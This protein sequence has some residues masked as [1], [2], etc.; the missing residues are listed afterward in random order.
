[1]TYHININKTNTKEFLQIADSLKKLG[2]IK[3]I[4][5]NK[6]LVKEGISLNEDILS[7]ILAFSKQEINDGQSFSMDDIK[8]QIEVWKKK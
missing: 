2:I 7:D 8:K 3:S 4:E 1:M 5:A 6:S